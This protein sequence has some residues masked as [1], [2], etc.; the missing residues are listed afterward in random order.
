MQHLSV[1]GR[2]QTDA[3]RLSRYGG[4]FAKPRAGQGEMSDIGAAVPVSDGNAEAAGHKAEHAAR[5][6]PE[7]VNE[8]PG[9]KALQS[10]A[11]EDRALKR[12]QFRGAA[13]FSKSPWTGNVSLAAMLNKARPQR[14]DREILGGRKSC[15]SQSFGA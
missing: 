6:V 5:W 9:R 4:R 13:F 3:T 12:W 2:G 15:G 7:P 14:S 10:A 1:S 11:V 8:F